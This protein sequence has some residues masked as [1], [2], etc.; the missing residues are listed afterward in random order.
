MIIKISQRNHSIS[1]APATSNRWPTTILRFL[2]PV[3]YH[4]SCTGYQKLKTLGCAMANRK[5]RELQPFLG[6]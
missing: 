3:K 5:W 6:A 1:R 2:L 4:S